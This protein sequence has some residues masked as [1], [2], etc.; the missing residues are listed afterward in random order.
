MDNKLFAPTITACAACIE[1]YNAAVAACVGVKDTEDITKLCTECITNCTYTINN[2]NDKSSYANEQA[3][4]AADVCR[5]AAAACGKS[6]VK[7]VSDAATDISKCE[8][9][10]K[11]LGLQ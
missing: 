4:V 11:K 5:A 6:S 8:A 2:C 10:C 3:R 9:A 1:S 7:A